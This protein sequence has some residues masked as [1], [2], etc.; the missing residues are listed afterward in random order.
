MALATG[1]GDA[2]IA[3][4]Q[5]RSATACISQLE[6]QEETQTQQSD[7]QQL[8]RPTPVN[9]K[10]HP[11]DA[12]QGHHRD[13]VDGD[14][15]A[16]PCRQLG[17]DVDAVVARASLNLSFYSLLAT[18]VFGVIGVLGIYLTYSLAYDALS[19]GRQGGGRNQP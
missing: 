8:A 3:G 18:L 7:A 11:A 14:A 13:G 17:R 6:Q 2:Y 9:K 19:A 5:Q 4:E 10:L 16:A 1:L 12:D 15:Q